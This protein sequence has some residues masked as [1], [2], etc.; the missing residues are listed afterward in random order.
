MG[1]GCCIIQLDGSSS[2]YAFPS[3]NI[4]SSVVEKVVAGCA[5]ILLRTPWRLQRPLCSH[6][7]IFSGI[8][9]I[10]PFLWTSGLAK[11]RVPRVFE[12]VQD[13]LTSPDWVIS[14]NGVPVYC[15]IQAQLLHFVYLCDENHDS[16]YTLGIT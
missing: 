1:Y 16:F 11:L 13:A 7:V 15:V 14:S 3:L 4:L 8:L 5:D 9:K 2:M 10:L 6:F 12:V